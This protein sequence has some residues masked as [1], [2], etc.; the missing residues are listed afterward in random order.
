MLLLHALK[1]GKRPLRKHMPEQLRALVVILLLAGS[2][3][4]LA[5]QPVSD[6]I[7]SRDFVRR[8]NL[9]F[10]LT[11]LAFLSHNFWL[12]ALVAG[13]LLLF[14]GQ[15]EPSRLAL[16]FFLLFLMPPVS[17][18]IPGLGLINYLFAMSYPRMLAFALLLPAALL[19]MSRKDVTSVGSTWPDRLLL[20]YLMMVVLLELRDSSMTNTLRQVLYVFIDVWLPYYVASRSM[21]RLADFKD[22]LA[23]FV[24]AAMVLAII[25]MFELLRHWHLYDA[26]V[27]A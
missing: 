20:S 27:N 18:E 26:L 11:L 14:V 5:R 23:G 7:N 6:V 2:V 17:A 19:L 24:L 16:F 8:R 10:A 12:F 1:F 9:W 4:A 25:G 22:A 3:F 13:T 15:R 21:Q